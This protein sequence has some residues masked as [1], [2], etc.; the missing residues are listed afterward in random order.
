MKEI[1]LK[2]VHRIKEIK[3]KAIIWLFWLSPSNVHILKL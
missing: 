3:R 1:T 2:I